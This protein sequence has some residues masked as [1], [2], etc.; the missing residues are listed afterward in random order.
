MEVFYY[1]AWKPPAQWD[2]GYRMGIRRYRTRLSG[3][4]E[5][6]RVIPQV[7]PVPDHLY[8][9]RV[10]IVRSINL[11]SLKYH[12]LHPEYLHNRIERLRGM[13]L[14]RVLLLICD[15]V[16]T[17]HCFRLHSRYPR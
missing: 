13:Y 6:L 15:I 17:A 1:L 2:Q 5:Y 16:S 14:L 8:A 3:R 7:S 9:S 11:S 12:R 10:L 4:T